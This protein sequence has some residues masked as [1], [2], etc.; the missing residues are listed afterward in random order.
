MQQEL[1][2]PE[3]Y[4]LSSLTYPEGSQ[5][6]EALLTA[7]ETGTR[8]E[9]VATMCDEK[10]N[11]YV[12][13][14]AERGIIPKEEAG[15]GEIKDI[16]LLAMVGKPVC[17]RIIGRDEDKWILSRKSLQEEAIGHLME[18]VGPGTI[19]PAKVTHLEQFGAFVDVGC[20]IISLVNVEH[21]SVSRIRNAAERFVPGQNLFVVV[22][23]VE[24]ASRRIYLSHK[25]LLGTWEENIMGFSPA[26][27]VSGIVRGVEKYGVFVELTPNLSGLAEPVERVR[28]GMEVTVFIKS[29]QPERMKIKLLIGSSREGDGRRLIIPSDYYLTEGRIARWQYQPERCSVRCIETD[30]TA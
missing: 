11:L 25:E 21:I 2:L 8:L 13:F 22:R 5:T 19:L 26:M 18:E 1:F 16:A 24:R 27:A 14:G 3:G 4:L 29:I 12:R 15:A 23:R 20:G 6:P 9:G 17:F 28:E 7:W 30:F 10:R